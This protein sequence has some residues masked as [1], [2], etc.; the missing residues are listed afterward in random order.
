MKIVVIGG[1]A[2]GMSAAARA[3]RLD[4]T[5][6]IVVFEKGQHVSFANCG[7]PY[8]VGGVIKD[9]DSLLLQTPLSLKSSLD[10]DVRVGQEVRGIDRAKHTVHV[11]ELETGR[12]YEESYDKLVLAPGA[13]PIRPNLPGIDHP[14]VLVLRNID[15]MDRIKAVV[16]GGAQRAIVIGGGY[17]GVEMAESLRERGLAVDLVEMV[18]QIM[19]PL[20]REMV[21]DLELHLRRHG[22]VLHLGAA[23]AAFRDHAGGVT[24]ELTNTEV[25]A[26]DLVILSVGVRPDTTLARRAGL[27]LGPRGGIKV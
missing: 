14:R 24:V 3:R 20:D 2:A 25:I 21:R 11:A 5:A 19:P 26:A 23:A 16:D 22:V 27:E 9:R 6:E 12:E 18:D 13:A 8:H 10:L 1:V 15:D 4:E 17:I 7:L